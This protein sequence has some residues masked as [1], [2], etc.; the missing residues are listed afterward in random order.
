LLRSQ[1]LHGTTVLMICKALSKNFLI[2]I[3]GILLK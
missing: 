3:F 2:L 1:A